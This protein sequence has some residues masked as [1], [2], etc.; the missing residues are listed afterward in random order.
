MPLS[1][2]SC[3]RQRVIAKLGLRPWSWLSVFVLTT[4]ASWYLTPQVLTLT[5]CS[6]ICSIERT[7]VHIAWNIMSLPHLDEVILHCVRKITR[8]RK[9]ICCRATVGP[10]DCWQLQDHATI[11]KGFAKMNC[12]NPQHFFDSRGVR[13]C[14]AFSKC[15]S[16]QGTCRFFWFFSALLN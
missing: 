6:I 12:S 15:N 5:S 16:A 9:K 14:Q 10:R 2:P 1:S 11:R 8:K 7:Q 3:L 4:A 13:I